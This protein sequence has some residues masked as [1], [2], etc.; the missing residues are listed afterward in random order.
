[1]IDLRKNTSPITIQFLKDNEGKSFW[2]NSNYSTN[3]ESFIMDAV[4]IDHF[5][6]FSHVLYK[7][8]PNF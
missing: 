6:T 7:L 4:M 2:F 3:R 8:S 5:T 1:M